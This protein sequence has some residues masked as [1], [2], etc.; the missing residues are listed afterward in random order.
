MGT[1]VWGLPRRIANC[2]GRYM[3]LVLCAAFAIG[4]QAQYSANVNFSTTYQTFEGWGTSL[5]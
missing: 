3:L 4:A 1:H 5:A 2:P